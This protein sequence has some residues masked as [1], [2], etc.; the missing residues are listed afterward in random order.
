MTI[1]DPTLYVAFLTKDTSTSLIIY[2]FTTSKVTPFISLSGAADT[3]QIK[4]SNTPNF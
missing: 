2:K 4:F 1:S 3:V